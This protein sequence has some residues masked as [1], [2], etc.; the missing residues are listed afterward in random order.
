MGV[1]LI[2]GLLTCLNR[3]RSNKQKK[4]RAPDFEDFG[5]AETDFPHQR[6]LP[7]ATT[8]AGAVAVSPTL[9][10]L[11]EQGN[12]YNDS[13]NRHYVPSYQPQLNS[14]Q[15]EYSPPM[16]HAQQPYYYPPQQPQEGYYDEHG[17][18]YQQ[19]QPQGG[20]YDMSA[21]GDYYKPDTADGSKPHQRM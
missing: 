4:K 19:Q 16:Q 13:A 10:R 5:L 12:F 8:S 1:A 9:P 14:A 11:N 18:Y 17:Y 20:M 2:G 6:S 3:R 15:P 7:T 21:A